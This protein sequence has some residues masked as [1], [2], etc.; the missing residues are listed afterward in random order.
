M[1][2]HTPMTDHNPAQAI[3]SKRASRVVLLLLLG[4]WLIA[5]L[6]RLSIQDQTPLSG[7]IFYAT[8]PL[9]LMITGLL[10]AFSFLKMRWRPEAAS[11][12]IAACL[13]GQSYWS[14]LPQLWFHQVQQS[15]GARNPVSD[16][17]VS[18]SN[19]REP[20]K[21]RLLFW[22]IG[23]GKA[24]LPRLAKEIQRY[25]ADVIGLVEGT[26]ATEEMRDFWTNAFPEY[27]FSQ[28]GGRFQLL[29]RFPVSD[30]TPGI[31]G[32][33]CLYRRV[34]FQIGNEQ[35]G[36]MLIDIESTPHK[37]RELTLTALA[38][39]VAEDSSEKLILMGD[40]NTP[41]DSRHYAKLRELIPHHAFEQNGFGPHATWPVP[42]PMMCLD[43][44]W[45][46]GFSAEQNLGTWHSTSWLSDHRN[47]V[48]DLQLENAGTSES[49]FVTQNRS[50]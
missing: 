18:F 47:V 11:I 38:D 21:L 13:A 31:V 36:L 33:M 22:N 1:Q 19:H 9:M 20:Q 6:I 34:D 26:L 44:V 40:F 8:P 50:F 25:N 39:Y 37:S 2:T 5:L 49:A 48:V 42:L 15:A 7:L 16:P 43:Q 23:R 30:C 45:L 29:T 3:W 32:D 35:V 10:L 24:G 28:L 27:H 14:D 41:D 4:C 12:A 46:K 17:Q